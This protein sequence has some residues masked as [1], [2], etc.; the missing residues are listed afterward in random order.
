M[1]VFDAGIAGLGA[2]GYFEDCRKAV[3]VEAALEGAIRLVH[4][5]CMNSAL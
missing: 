4:R 5:E 2:L 3:I 1:K